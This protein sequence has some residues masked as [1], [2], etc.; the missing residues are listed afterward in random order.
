MKPS[1][2][3]PDEANRLREAVVSAV[4]SDEHGRLRSLLSRLARLRVDVGVLQSS[5][6][7]HLVADR[8][9]WS[10][11]GLDVL[12]KAQAL[13]AK[14]RSMARKQRMSGAKEAQFPSCKPSWWTQ[15]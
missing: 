7:G 9:I 10:C 1:D 4:C 14:W 11:G 15:R 6:V 12:R 8:H 13:H 2:S 3:A 5:G